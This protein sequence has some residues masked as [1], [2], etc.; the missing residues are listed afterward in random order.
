MI[1]RL[2]DPL[3]WVGPCTL[4]AKLIMQRI[5]EQDLTWD[6]EVCGTIKQDFQL[7]LND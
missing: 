2:Y 5:W 1:S 6:D 7:F 3:G 4:H